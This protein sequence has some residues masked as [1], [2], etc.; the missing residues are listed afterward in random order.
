MTRSPNLSVKLTIKS[1]VIV[2]LLLCLT[3]SC[4]N[5]DEPNCVD[6][7]KIRQGACP[8]IYLPVCGCNGVTYGNSCEAGNAGVLRWT[9][10]ACSN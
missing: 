3:Q 5:E 2:A 10:G 7:S 1:I 8:T 4:D 9:S 6:P